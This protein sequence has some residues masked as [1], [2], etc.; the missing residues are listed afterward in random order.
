V[1]R[2]SRF[3]SGAWKAVV[4]MLALT[5]LA[6]SDAPGVKGATSPEMIS[7]VP[8]SGSI[9]RRPSAAVPG[10][11]LAGKEWRLVEIQSMDDTVGTVRPDDPSRYTMRLNGDG[12][13]TMRLS[14]NSA[15]GNWSAEASTDQSSGGFE[16]GPLAA[17]R[18]HCPPPSLDQQVSSQAQ[19]VR[20]YLLKD[21]RLH[22]SLMADGG[23]YVWEPETEAPFQTKPDKD[24]DAAILR[25]SPYYTRKVV[26]VEGGT[27]RGRYVYGRVDLNGD[28]RDEVFVYLLGSIFCGTGGCNL[29]LFTDTN[30]GYSLI[31]EFPISRLP[32]IVSAKRTKGWHDLIRLES[33]SGA[34]ASYVRHTFDGNRY[35][36]RESMP[37]DKVP[38]GKSYLAGELTFDKG[39][40][41]EPRN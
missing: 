32:V 2:K 18:A 26:D 8:E 1:N 38:E 5:V 4:M 35:V 3:V 40:S 20:S 27:G 34:E 7:P 9:V 33:G 24:L 11:L 16:F 19:Y 29:L 30:N 21:G 17:T 31:N 28:G 41:L 23:I 36:E 22:L 13:V 25:A 37:A 39:I 10:N 6:A 12:T 14:C 15:S